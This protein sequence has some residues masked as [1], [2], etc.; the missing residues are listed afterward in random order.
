MTER[1]GTL[2]GLGLGPGDPELMTLKAA[3]LLSTAPV[4][5]YLKPND[6][7]S[8]ARAIAAAHLPGHHTEVGI[9]MPM[10]ADSAPGQSAYDAGA[11]VIA[12]HLDAGRDVAF[13][14]EGDPFLFG[15]FMYLFDRLSAD[16]PV[17]TVPGVSSPSAASAAAG[18]PLVS[19]HE[20]LLML[21]A[22]LDEEALVDRL[23][24]A[25]A[26]VIMKLGRH[27]EKA[28]RALQT[29]GMADGARVVVR[30]SQDDQAIVALADA[31]ASQP[32]FSLILARRSESLP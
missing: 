31:D 21:P 10:R 19:R 23:A 17:V 7:D 13:L 2:Y 18:L 15:S 29:A 5:A 6:G 26:A 1:K 20:S 3:R 32:Y 28:R 8:I 12:G 27:F 22:T 25:D 30:A 9:S 11:I 14:C 24:H 16:Y 4:I